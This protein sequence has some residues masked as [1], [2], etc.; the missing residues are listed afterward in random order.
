MCLSCRRNEEGIIQ[1]GGAGGMG[2]NVGKGE[3]GI[4]DCGGKVNMTQAEM[5][6]DT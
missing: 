5:H 2:L 1:M 6:A 3:R 4:R